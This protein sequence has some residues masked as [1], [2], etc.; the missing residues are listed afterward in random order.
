MSLEGGCSGQGPSLL[1]GAKNGGEPS[2]QN[3]SVKALPVSIH[4]WFGLVCLRLSSRVGEKGDVQYFYDAKLGV[5]SSFAVSSVLVSVLLAYTNGGL[6]WGGDYIG[7]YTANQFFRIPSPASAVYCAAIAL[8]GGNP[9]AGFYLGLFLSA[10]FAGF[11]AFT[12]AAQ[13]AR[14]GLPR[15]MY[16]SV[17]V[18]TTLLYTFNPYTVTDTFKSIVVSTYPFVG[19][20]FLFLAFSVRLWR[21]RKGEG[22]T[23]F[24]DWG[25]LGA[26][27][28]LSLETY[29]N[30]FRIALFGLAWLGIILLA[31]RRRSSSATK[32]SLHRTWGVRTLA[33][34]AFLFLGALYSIWPYLPN[35][36]G[37]VSQS[38]GTAAG[39]GS[40]GLL[41]G[42]SYSQ[43]AFVIRLQDSWGFFSGF[44]PYSSLYSSSIPLE[45]ATW[46]W[47]ILAIA[48]PL[49]L[50]R[51]FVD[52]DLLLLLEVTLL[53]C[54]AWETSP[55]PPTGVAY[56]YVTKVAPW[57]VSIVPNGFLSLLAISKFYAILASISIAGIASSIALRFA[58][59]KGPYNKIGIGIPHR[60]GLRRRGSSQKVAR[61]TASIA[62]VLVLL[63]AAYPTFA[64][65][66]EGQ[67]FDESEKGFAI[68][69]SYWSV[70]QDL[71]TQPGSMFLLPAMSTY[72]Q[73]AWG[74]Q[75]GEEFY[76]AFFYPKTVLT[77]DSFAPLLG[78]G[79]YSTAAVALESALTSPLVP[80]NVT[81]ASPASDRLLLDHTIVWGTTYQVDSDS[82][83]IRLN[84]SSTPQIQLTIPFNGPFDATPYK[85]LEFVLGGPNLQLLSQDF[86]DGSARIGLQSLNSSQGGTIGW[87]APN[88]DLY[89]YAYLGEN[90]TMT[91]DVDVGQLNSAYP[92]DTYNSSNIDD[93]IIQ[94]PGFGAGFVSD[95]VFE[96]SAVLTGFSIAQGWSELLARF[97]VGQ[98][99][100][101]SS[102]EEGTLQSANYVDLVV[103]AIQFSGYGRVSFSEPPLE[104][105]EI[106]PMAADPPPS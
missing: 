25:L 71:L 10:A 84:E 89:S 92:T 29:P 68:P 8:V 101:D 50:I 99:L 34:P 24:G 9:Y 57:L 12:F 19:F 87:Y 65:L 72:V 95:F 105:I 32:S 106:P 45:L 74:Y 75:G 85:L 76:P 7:F 93:L 54:I 43:V 15:S 64:G 31:T 46:L 100:F 4:R 38:V 77:V 11:G 28:G 6:L 79:T 33:F 88:S 40:T 16:L 20:Q 97:G 73:T 56:A 102:V 81:A 18:M 41:S 83:S 80:N 53:G 44:A 96:S 23:T 35:L 63:L 36:K 39:F 27:L 14:A 30:N 55:N 78:Y 82:N 5:L 60:L 67:Y 1:D 21:I 66:S 104:L 26:T 90:G 22:T 91:L 17:P 103:R 69:A 61:A 62:L 98:I 13:V 3:S 52:R 70:R 42:G 2:V 47:P 86:A 59:E 94:A 49:L 48:T 37:A 58:S 51:K